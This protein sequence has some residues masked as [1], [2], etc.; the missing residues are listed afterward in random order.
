VHA[1][2]LGQV[3]NFRPTIVGGT[4]KHCID[5]Y[6]IFSILFATGKTAMPGGLY[7]RLCHAFLVFFVIH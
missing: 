7:T 5:Q 6:I 4:A 3:T 1:G 2:K